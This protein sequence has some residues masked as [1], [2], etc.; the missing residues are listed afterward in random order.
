MLRE[1]NDIFAQGYKTVD[2]VEAELNEAFGESFSYIDPVRTN[3]RT[4]LRFCKG[5]LSSPSQRLPTPADDGRAH[6]Q[7]GGER[8]FQAR[9]RQ[10]QGHLLQH[11]VCQVDDPRHG[12]HAPQNNTELI[13]I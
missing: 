11:D 10:T 13:Y 12:E 5:L 6:A 7:R 1:Y 4:K 8:V 9:P 3:A 2:A